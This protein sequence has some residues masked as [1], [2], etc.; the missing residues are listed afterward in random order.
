MAVDRKD[1]ENG[2]LGRKSWFLKD[3]IGVIQTMKS[4]KKS[5]ARRVTIDGLWNR[6]GRTL[7]RKGYCKADI[8]E[9]IKQARKAE[10]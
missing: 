9:L 6:I 2:F 3:S 7:K 8:P 5:F 4:R 1:G 10:K